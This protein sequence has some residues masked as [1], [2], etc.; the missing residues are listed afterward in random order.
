MNLRYHF[1]DWYLVEFQWGFEP[2]NWNWFHWHVN[3][4]DELRPRKTFPEKNIFVRL[5]KVSKQSSKLTARTLGT[6][7]IGNGKVCWASWGSSGFGQT[8]LP[9]VKLYEA[10]VTPASSF[11]IEFG[12]AWM[13]FIEDLEGHSALGWPLYNFLSNMKE[14]ALPW[15]WGS[16]TRSHTKF[17]P[18]IVFLFFSARPPKFWPRS[19]GGRK[20]KVGILVWN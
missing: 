8:H 4:E 16:T 12:S 1:V 9:N 18:K 14:A 20:S 6:M 11:S 10:K 7:S 5:W 15:L 17:G 3:P 2:P 19:T 13:L